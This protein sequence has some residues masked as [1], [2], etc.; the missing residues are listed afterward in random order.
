MTLKQWILE[1]IGKNNKDVFRHLMI[2]KNFWKLL[3]NKIDTV[4][5]YVSIHAKLLQLGLALCHAMDRS[6]SSSS[7][8]GI[9]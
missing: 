2:I 6:P 8:H 9:L 4:L 7:L 3:N 5:Y 1:F